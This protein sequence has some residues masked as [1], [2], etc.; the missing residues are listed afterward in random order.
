MKYR[1]VA[2]LANG[3]RVVG[4]SSDF[5]AANRKADAYLL[6]L[7]PNTDECPEMVVEVNY[8]AR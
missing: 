6:S 1:I 8:G 2:M 5:A 7:D 4:Y 3:W